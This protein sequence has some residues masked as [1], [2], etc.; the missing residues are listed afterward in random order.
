MQKIT[1]FL[2]FDNCAEEAM[3]FYVDTF[4][5][6]P[7]ST[8]TDQAN[9]SDESKIL[10]IKR[11]PSGMSDEHMTGMEGK[12][13]T[14]VFTLAG[15]KF[16]ALDGGPLFK[17]N[18]SVSFLV[19]CDDQAEVNYFWDTITKNGGMESEC[20]WCKDKYGF[21]WQIAPNMAQYLATP[22]G[23]ANN[24]AIQAMLKMKKIDIA[25]LEEA[26]KGN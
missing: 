15:Q 22:D 20:G 7:H 2:W 10:E 4:K 1:P 25:K 17:P 14:G 11:Y 23:E 13:L 5:N 3:N 12:V 6:S 21:S 18:E 26:Y 19:N 24:R 8:S 16:M 9:K